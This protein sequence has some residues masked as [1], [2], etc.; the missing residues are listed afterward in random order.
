MSVTPELEAMASAMFVKE[1]EHGQSAEELAEIWGAMGEK[2]S[3]TRRQFIE[4]ARAGLAAIREPSDRLKE[5]GGREHMEW[6]YSAC[7]DDAA[8]MFETMIDAIIGDAE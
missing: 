3:S 8:G 2:D 6:P 5:I 1:Y 4:L 7:V